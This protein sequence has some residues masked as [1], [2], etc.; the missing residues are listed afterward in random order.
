MLCK[1]E[2]FLLHMC[3][4]NAT[5]INISCISWRSILLL[6]QTEYPEKTTDLPQVT[7]KLYHILFLIYTHT[8]TH[9]YMKYQSWK[10]E[11]VNILIVSRCVINLY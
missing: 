7:D 5:F 10:K 9:I 2:Q 4:F 11:R 1:G 8:Y 6:E 3:L